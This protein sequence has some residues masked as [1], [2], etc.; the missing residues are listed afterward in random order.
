MKE[1]GAKIL[2]VIDTNVFVSALL[3]R[4]G[5]SN[6]AII[7]N[8]IYEGL[9]QPVYNEEIIAEYR[10]VLS[11]PKFSIITPAEIEL[12]I[13]SII[14]MGIN[15]NRIPITDEEF[16]DP[17]DVVFYEVKMSVEEAYL[18]TGNIKHFPYKPFIVTPAQMV[19]I[20][21][22]IEGLSEWNH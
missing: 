1:K 11:R 13:A 4:N 12:L 3:S 18:V 6:P 7:L 10:E 9:I 19:E 17:D 14:T 8:K 5:T 2:A 16:N 15:T 22:N 20:I 21:A